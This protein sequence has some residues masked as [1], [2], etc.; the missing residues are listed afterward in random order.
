[1]AHNVIA[2]G[3]WCAVGEGPL[4]VSDPP[5]ARY[6]LGLDAKPPSARARQR[7]DFGLLPVTHFRHSIP[8]LTKSRLRELERLLSGGT[9]LFRDAYHN[10]VVNQGLDDLLSIMLASGTQDTTWFIGL[11]SGTPTAA[12]GDTLAS[13]A[14]WTEVSNYTQVNRV[15]WVP[16]AVASASV[17]NTASPA[18]FTINATVTVGG[19]FL[20]G[21]N[22]GT[23][24]RLYSAGAFT[25]GNKLL[26]NLDSLSVTNTFTMTAS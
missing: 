6:L 22:T 1:M 5:K 18:A 10:I 25:A 12:A 7:R 9:L 17:S 2:E 19:S 24:G 26:N 21:V 3:H 11:T 14:G 16:G 15:A 8:S 4:L 23:A 20:A 13:H